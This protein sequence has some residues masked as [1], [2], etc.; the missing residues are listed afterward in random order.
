MWFQLR[1]IEWNSCQFCPRDITS[2]SYFKSSLRCRCRFLF[3]WPHVGCPQ[4]R[5]WHLLSTLQDGAKGRK[6]LCPATEPWWRDTAAISAAS[7]LSLVPPC[8]GEVAV[9]VGRRGGYGCPC[10]PDWDSF[11]WQSAPSLSGSFHLAF[12]KFSPI[13]YLDALIPFSSQASC[14]R[15]SR[16]RP[17]S[18]WVPFT[19]CWRHTLFCISFW[20]SLTQ[21]WSQVASL[22]SFPI[23]FGR[24][25][26]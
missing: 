1:L 22:G 14:G 11:F 23:S 2:R 20:L 26:G 25:P 16:S 18:Q 7:V 24:E 5:C 10:L 17:G 12:P 19:P 8:C 13:T 4:A 9:A 15:R 6:M 3:M 21:L